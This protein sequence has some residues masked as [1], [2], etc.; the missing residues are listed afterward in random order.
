M[1]DFAK[2]HFTEA[3]GEVKG[4]PKLDSSMSVPKAGRSHMG[5]MRVGFARY[6]PFIPRH[7]PSPI[8]SGDGKCVSV[9][10]W[11]MVRREQVLN[12]ETDPYVILF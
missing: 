12:Q 3:R 5:H 4:L 10:Q 7:V 9:R 6:K 8:H 1:V 2:H 11:T